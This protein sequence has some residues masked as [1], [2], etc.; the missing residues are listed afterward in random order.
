MSSI[1]P[2]KSSIGRFPGR[3]HRRMLRGSSKASPP[4]HSKPKAP[5][6]RC[7][8]PIKVAD[9]AKPSA[10][11]DG[12]PLLLLL[13]AVMN[14]PDQDTLIR[15]VEDAR[16]ILGEYLERGPRDAIRTV[17]HLLGRTR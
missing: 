2:D 9:H 1:C 6:L 14:D 17:Q 16:R 7:K 3:N 10:Q 8:R 11:V 15:A 5:S 12:L 13:R 4:P